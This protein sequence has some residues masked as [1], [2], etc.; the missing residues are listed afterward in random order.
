MLE[1]N[2]KKQ[3][4]AGN[5]PYKMCF[6]IQH[7]SRL[8]NIKIT[9]MSVIYINFCPKFTVFCVEINSLIWVGSSAKKHNSVCRRWEVFGWLKIIR[10]KTQKVIWYLNHIMISVTFLSYLWLCQNIHS[11]DLDNRLAGQNSTTSFQRPQNCWSRWARL[12][13][14]TWTWRSASRWTR[15]THFLQ[16]R[17]Q[18]LI[19]FPYLWHCWA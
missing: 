7:F 16:C 13:G 3:K 14:Y 12:S 8:K 15:D 17:S 1:T 19:F 11:F 4:E 9:F 10:K 5:G 18:I 6:N 2:E